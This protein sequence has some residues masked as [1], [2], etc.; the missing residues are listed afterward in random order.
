MAC[1]RPVCF[2]INEIADHRG[3]SVRCETHRPCPQWVNRVVSSA[4]R[5]YWGHGLNSVEGC[6]VQFV[7]MLRTLSLNPEE[8]EKL[9]IAYEDALRAL[10]FPT[11]RSHHNDR[12]PTDHRSR[13]SSR[14]GFGRT[15]RVGDQRPQGSVDPCLFMFSPSKQIGE[16]L[17]QCSAVW[18]RLRSLWRPSTCMFWTAD[19]FMPSNQ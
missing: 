14:A 7:S 17:N 4:L 8:L 6:D 15:L 19:T 9:S 13:Q 10:C 16:T 12:R 2:Y 18:R 11:N 3:R 1:S 5:P